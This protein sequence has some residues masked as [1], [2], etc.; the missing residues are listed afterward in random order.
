MKRCTRPLG[1]KEH[2]TMKNMVLIQVW[3]E[4]GMLK[5][6]AA[7]PE[8]FLPVHMRGSIHSTFDRQD[9]SS[10]KSFAQRGA[11]VSGAIATVST[12]LVMRF[13]AFPAALLGLPLGREKGD[14]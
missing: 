12:G 5:A 2:S 7:S 11:P 8:C 13:P 1:G 4:G 3:F 9:Q 10:F 14:R 6:A